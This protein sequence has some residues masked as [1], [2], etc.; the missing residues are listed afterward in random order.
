MK[1][2]AVRVLSVVATT[3]AVAH[4]EPLSCSISDSDFGREDPNLQIME[5]DVGDGPQ[6]TKVYVEPNV[7]SFYRLYDT[8]P[9]TQKVV[10]MFDGFQCKFVNLSNQ[11][12]VFSWEDT[13]SGQ[14]HVMRYLEPWTATGTASFPNHQFV[15][16]PMEE[17]PDSPNV[18]VRLQVQEYPHNNYYY[19]PYHIRDHPEPPSFLNTRQQESYRQW[20]KTVLFDDQYKAKTGRSYLANYLRQPPR[21]SIWPAE[22]FGQEH[23]VVTQERHFQSIP[24]D[25]KLTKI[26]HH[27]KSRRLTEPSLPEYRVDDS[28]A[29]NLTLR[30]ISVAPRVLEI[31]NFLSE[32]E[33]QHILEL[34]VKL[35]MKKSTTGDALNRETAQLKTRTSK[36]TWV[37]REESPIVDAV[38][39]R[40][41]DVQ[42]MDEALLRYRDA[43][44]RP[45]VTG[46]RSLGEHLQLV[47]YNAGQEYTAHHDFGFAR[48]DDEQQG[49]RFSTLLLY[50][51][52]V[53]KGGE[54]SFP[55]W[56]NAET[57][58]KLKVKPQAGKAVLF[59][60]QLPDGNFDDLSHHAA[61]PVI[62]GEKY[63]I[64]L[65][66]WYV[67]STFCAVVRG[68]HF[69]MCPAAW[70]DSLYQFSLSLFLYSRDPVYERG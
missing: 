26:T 69:R 31:E 68:L 32:A 48:M 34:A 49:A 44:E 37:P 11:S 22:Y 13:K 58:H 33:V 15:M 47:H 25:E 35:D 7:T 60:S 55:R 66:T 28:T 5:Y 65:W 64:N 67:C 4:S 56:S 39:R 3:A 51:N 10:P 36:N 29:L 42:L 1:S 9:S 19:D 62:V 12:V 61:E 46:R 17:G 59:Y 6:K 43:D 63:L 52:D 2:F 21:H 24:P 27:G 70:T 16:T 53:P 50:L 8:P 23:W 41:A 38:Y 54:T 18:L 40:A 20:R 57:F 30:V 45:D 14:R